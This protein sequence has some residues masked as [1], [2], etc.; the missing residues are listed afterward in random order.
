MV[1]SGAFSLPGAA[2][3]YV[4]VRMG[5]T[6][7]DEDGRSV[8]TRGGIRQIV[9]LLEWAVGAEIRRM[10][11]IVEAYLGVLYVVGQHI[12]LLMQHQKIQKSVAICIATSLIRQDSDIYGPNP[13]N[14]LLLTSTLHRNA[15][16]EFYMSK[17][18][19]STEPSSMA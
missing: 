18:M 17:Y 14:A 16:L 13:P 3:R 1:M 11:V 9:R 7:G 12:R 6:S 5:M 15:T 10:E 2:A 19:S 4:I 8:R